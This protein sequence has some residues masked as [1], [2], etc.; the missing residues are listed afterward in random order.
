[1]KKHGA[2]LHLLA[3]LE[4][5]DRVV[6]GLAAWCAGILEVDEARPR[7]EALLDE[8]TEIVLYGGQGLV[9]CL[10]GHLAREAIGRLD[11]KGC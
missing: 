7:L 11:K 10:A 1:M 3:F 6:R 8:E 4:S 5:S 2:D 9:K